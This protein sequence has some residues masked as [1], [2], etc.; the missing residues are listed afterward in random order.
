MMRS[1]STSRSL[2]FCIEYEIRS[3]DWYKYSLDSGHT[4]YAAL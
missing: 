3:S 1:F 4:K 2:V